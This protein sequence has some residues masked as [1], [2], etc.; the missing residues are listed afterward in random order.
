MRRVKPVVEVKERDAQR[1]VTMLEQGAGTSRPSSFHQASTNMSGFR[2][3]QSARG[4][5]RGR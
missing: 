3:A 4:Q 1:F 5:A 2:S